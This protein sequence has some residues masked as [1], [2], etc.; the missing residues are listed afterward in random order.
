MGDRATYV[1]GS[2]RHTFTTRDPL[3]DSRNTE[4]TEA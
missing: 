4:R 3:T 1:V 2:G